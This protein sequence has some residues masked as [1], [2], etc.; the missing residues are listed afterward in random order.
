MKLPRVIRRL[1][2]FLVALFLLLAATV[3]GLWVYFHPR[4]HYQSGIVYS[5]RQGRDLTL[6]VVRPAHPNGIGILLLVSG[7]WKSHPDSFRPWIAAPLLR[8]GYTIFPVYHISQPQ[9][10][11]MEIAEDMH[12]AVRFVR[13]HAR[14]YGVDPNRLGVTGGSAGG[15][16]SL[17]LATRGA[18]GPAEAPDPVDHES[19]AVQ[20]VAIFYPVTDLLNLGSSTENPGDGGPP[21]SF[22]KGFGPEATNLAVWKVIGR[23]L[24]PIYYVTSNLPPCLIFHGDADTLVP[25][26]QSQRFQAEAAKVGAT[27]ELVVHPGGR[28][29]WP[30]MLWDIR[31]FADWFD[32]YLQPSGR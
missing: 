27:V 4:H 2:I 8:R 17:L 19:S 15:H 28:H 22:V 13:H 5:Q 31:R 24:S 14:Q 10:T 21:K 16:L 1:F 7:G 9:A 6:D 20:A 26:D 12:R 32:R 30:T 29:G 18:P 23:E 3:G 11:I 25:L